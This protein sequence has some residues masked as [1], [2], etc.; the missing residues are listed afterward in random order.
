MSIDVFADYSFSMQIYDP[1]AR[2]VKTKMS[3]ISPTCK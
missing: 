2:T 1:Y 3:T